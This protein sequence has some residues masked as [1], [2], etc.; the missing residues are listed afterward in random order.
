MESIGI[1][2]G[3]IVTFC[4]GYALGK[5]NSIIEETVSGGTRVVQKF[6]DR[7]HTGT[8]KRPSAEEIQRRKDP[9]QLEEEQVMRETFDK[10]NEEE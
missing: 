7:T 4:L 9:K 8:I 2:I 10:L 5:R 6:F 1:W 3:T